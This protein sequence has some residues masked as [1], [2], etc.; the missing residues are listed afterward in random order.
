M[1][2]EIRSCLAQQ[3]Y[4][5]REFRRADYIF[6]G[7]L[8]SNLFLLLELV[9]CEYGLCTEIQL[10]LVFT[11]TVFRLDGAILFDDETGV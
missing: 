10:D 4:R 8:K 7:V 11:Y 3:A 2:A 6:K 1:G 9:R 5:R